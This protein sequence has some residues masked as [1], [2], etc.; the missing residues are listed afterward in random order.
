VDANADAETPVDLGEVVDMIKDAKTTVSYACKL[1]KDQVPHMVI[2]MDKG[3][4]VHVHAPFENRYLMNQFQEAI[5]R[6]QNKYNRK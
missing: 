4:N 2:M 5:I 3:G 6:E 1:C